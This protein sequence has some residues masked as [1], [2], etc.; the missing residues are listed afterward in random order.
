MLSLLLARWHIYQIFFVHLKYFRRQL[1]LHSLLELHLD[2]TFRLSV[3][4]TGLCFLAMALAYTSATVLTTEQL[5][6]V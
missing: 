4:A 2:T 1:L 6:T 5:L 3:A